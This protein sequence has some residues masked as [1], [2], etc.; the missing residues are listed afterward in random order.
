MPTRFGAWGKAHGLNLAEV[1]LTGTA[2]ALLRRAGLVAMLPIWVY[3]TLLVVAGLFGGVTFKWWPPNSSTRNLH[4]RMASQVAATTPVLYATGWGPTLAIGYMFLV[5]DGLR[6]DGSRATRP[7]LFWSAVGMGL[8]QGAIALGVAPSFVSVPEVH[9]LAVLVFL[10]L[11]FAI[12]NA[13]RTTAEKERA[14]ADARRSEQRFRSLVQN[15]ADVV[16][17]TQPDGAISYVSPAVERVVGHSAEA[18][19]SG[20]GFLHPEDEPRSRA[21]FIDVQRHPGAMVSY[22]ARVGHADGSWHWQEVTLTNLL[23]DPSVEGIVANFH[24]VTER[25]R[26]EEHLADAAYHDRL[27]GL[28]NRAGFAE[29]MNQALSRARRRGAGI[30][31]LFLDLDRL[32]VV[33]DTLG[34]EVGDQVLVEV[35]ARLNSCCRAEDTVA[36]FGGDEFTMLLEDTDGARAAEV[37]TRITQELRRPA[38]IA[39]RE[40][41]V[42]ASVGLALSS[43]GHETFDELLRNADL[44]M[45]LAKERGRGRWEAFEVEMGSGIVDRYRLESDLRQA[46]EQGDLV[47]HYQPEVSL[48]TFEVVGFEALVRWQHP[49]RGLL[50]P[51]CFVPMAEESDLILE[52]DAHALDRACRQMSEWQASELNPSGLIMSVNVSSRTLNSEGANALLDVIERSGVD[53]RGLQ[54]EITETAAMADVE[55]SL[56]ALRALRRLGVRLAIDD[57]GTG[58]SSLACLERLPVDVLKVDRGFV[59][60]LE[61]L[62]AGATSLAIVKA[63]ISLGHGLGMRVTGEGVETPD[64]ATCLRAL[65]CD[66]AQGS[67]FGDALPAESASALLAQGLAGVEPAVS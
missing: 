17:V 16:A 35:A 48:E 66:T 34:H 59:A 53:P 18:F 55:E 5:T 8:G 65:G 36:R 43:T 47:V 24:D 50:G 41:S 52:I 7:A 40:L 22:E 26:F 11:G 38:R 30:A 32:K 60:G 45:Y 54:L 13:G 2:F 14:E 51:A 67:F 21:L 23:D 46:V 64:Q 20:G 4:L 31:L 57:F 33:N 58:Y 39:G 25:K 63:V 15:G 12:Y 61:D 19:V 28:W 6:H 44:A 29:R 62:E 9:G 42:T 49:E 10:G 3:G 1:A 27:T 56:V 37:A